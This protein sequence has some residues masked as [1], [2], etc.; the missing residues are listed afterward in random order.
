[1]QGKF[2]DGSE[3]CC[4]WVAVGT[5]S[6]STDQTAQTGETG[7]MADPGHASGL[8]ALIAANESNGIG[9]RGIA[10]AARL[11]SLNAVAIGNDS[12]ITQAMKV[13]VGSGAAVINNSWSPPD[14]GQG[15]SRSFYPAPAGWYEALDEAQNLGR[16]GLGAIVVKAAGNGGASL[17]PSRLASDSGDQANYD[18]FAQHPALISVAAVDA[19]GKPLASSEPGAQ[20]LI[21][22]F[23]S[24]TNT[25]AVSTGTEALPEGSSTAAAMVSAVA[26]LILEAQPRLSW[27]DLRWILAASARPIPGYDQA[28]VSTAVSSLRDHGFHQK[29]GFGLIDA[30]AAIDMAKGFPGLPPAL[31]CAYDASST[32][33][34]AAASRP[35][36]SAFLSWQQL[37]IQQDSGTV[38]FSF[39]LPIG[40]CSVERIESVLL[41][42][43][44]SHQDAT[45]LRLTLISPTGRGVQ[46][47]A[48]RDCNQASC[49]NLN[50]GFQF[51]SVRFM[52]E[53][54]YG[55]WTLQIREESGKSSGQLSALRLN[56]IGH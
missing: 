31:R 12:R 1:L 14:P 48:P 3:V 45:G 43:A 24:H 55:L 28:G 46:L 21:S 35:G 22:A 13:A 26:A 16:T 33:P 2:L 27:R 41:S 42:I 36:S 44:T 38:S 5:Q 47:A 37:P 56:I 51:H 18:G 32:P 29:V 4:A 8:A 34:M 6:G 53:A 25:P 11:L 49:T 20:V 17:S 54:A 10:S 7:P 39:N 40:T 19:Y 15:G 9:G 23:S 50:K 52:A 30:G